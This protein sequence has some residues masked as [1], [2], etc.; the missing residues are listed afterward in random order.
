MLK[1]GIPLI[2]LILVIIYIIF[3]L[4][5]KT[6]TDTP[7][8]HAGIHIV[9]VVIHLAIS[10]V[11]LFSCFAYLGF[12]FGTYDM[13]EL[14][15]IC[16]IVGMSVLILNLHALINLYQAGVYL[17]SAPTRSGMK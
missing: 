7:I 10:W 11:L 1:L 15:W 5:H 17:Q 8:K 12:G 16:G 13:N 14:K 6:H 2:L 3:S 4:L 9:N